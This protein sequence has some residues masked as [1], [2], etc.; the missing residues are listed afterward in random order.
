MITKQPPTDRAKVTLI[1]TRN[2]ASHVVSILWTNDA[3]HVDDFDLT[4]LG[5]VASV[6]DDLFAC[7][8]RGW[9]TLD[10]VCL[11]RRGTILKPLPRKSRPRR[12]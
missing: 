6:Q 5:N 11:R 9:V 3:L 10:G 7:P 2:P 8:P 1:D 12:L 4:S